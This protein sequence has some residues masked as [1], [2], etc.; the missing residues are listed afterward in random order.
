MSKSML[1]ICQDSPWAGATAK[2]TL[3]LALSGGA[4][5]LPISLLFLEDGIFQLVGNQLPQLIEQKNLTANLQAL[6]LFGITQLL[7]DEQSLVTRGLTTQQLSQ[8]VTLIK[9]TE[10]GSLL[11][12]YDTVITS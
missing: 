6:P 7:V 9:R 12:D 3:D 10:L 8:P 5:D 4:F 1:I 11:I 2:E